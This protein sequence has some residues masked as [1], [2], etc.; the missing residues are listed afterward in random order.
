MPIILQLKT[1]D[2]KKNKSLGRLFMWYCM[3]KNISHYN[4]MVSNSLSQ[5]V[6]QSTSPPVPYMILEL[7][8]CFCLSEIL[9][10]FIFFPH[11]VFKQF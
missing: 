11:Q 7:G 4:T 8:F 1:E 10:E 6:H 3:I 2:R 9:Y 5:T